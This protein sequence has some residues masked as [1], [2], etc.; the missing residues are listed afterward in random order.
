[1][2]AKD[3]PEL[4][5]REPTTKPFDRQQISEQATVVHNLKSLGAVLLPQNKRPPA[6][7][8]GGDE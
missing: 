2:T 8:S 5:E 4:P 6:G 1:M 7:F 3:K